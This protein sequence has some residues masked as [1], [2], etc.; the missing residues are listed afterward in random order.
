MIN[1]ELLFY[2]DM[3]GNYVYNRVSIKKFV[4]G[5]EEIIC[6]KLSFLMLMALY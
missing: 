3:M 5:R 6:I 2:F 4:N 1:E